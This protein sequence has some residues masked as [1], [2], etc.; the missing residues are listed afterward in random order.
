MTR[1]K[2]KII[3]KI[4]K[5]IFIIISIGVVFCYFSRQYKDYLQELEDLKIVQE[6]EKELNY[7]NNIFEEIIPENP[8]ES[9]ERIVINSKDLL[10]SNTNYIGV[11]EMP[12]LGIKKPIIEGIT[13]QAIASK[14][15]W[16]PHSSMPGNGGNVAL[17]AHNAANY[18]GKIRYLNN[19]DKII[20]T[21]RDGV[22]TYKVFDKFKVHKTE[23]WIYNKLDNYEETVTL[24]TCSYP[25]SENRWIVRGELIN[26]EEL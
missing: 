12:T 15:G 21:T 6:L 9:V 4:T 11:I 13:K 1:K 22:F 16:E 18:F 26:I 3:N 23:V 19:G 25:D 8:A 2:K 5:Y 24:I 7:N 17:A 10:I 20:V 14:V